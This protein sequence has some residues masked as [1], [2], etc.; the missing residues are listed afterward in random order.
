MSFAT[1]LLH[2]NGCIEIAF[3]QDERA[4]NQ[5]WEL[6]HNLAYTY[7]HSAPGKRLMTTDAVVPINSLPEAIENSRK[8]IE[9][10][11]LDAGIVGHVGDGN[12]HI[13]QQIYAILKET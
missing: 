11:N 1:E 8:K 13:L 6:R 2:D 9:N 10:M 3:E 5:L 12:Y 4:R 7:I